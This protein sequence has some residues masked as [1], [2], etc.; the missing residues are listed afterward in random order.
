MA[1]EHLTE[2]QLHAYTRRSLPPDGLLSVSDHL[3]KCG[4]CRARAVR[5]RNESSPDLTY[6]ELVA[7]LDENTDPVQRRLLSEKLRHSPRSRAELN[8][9]LHFRQKLR[10][11]PPNE[12]GDNRV[13]VFPRTFLRVAL[14]LAAAIV[15]AAGA[16]WW[17]M[18]EKGKTITLRDA[19]RSI[20]L[21]PNGRLIGLAG[22]PN[23]LEHSV[24][25]ALRTGQLQIP[26]AI[27]GL[28]GD[29]GVLAGE[30][31]KLSEFRLMAPIATAVQE[32]R[33]RFCW[34]AQAGAE[35]YQIHIVDFESGETIVTGKSDGSKTEW[36]PAAPLAIGRIYQWQVDAV[37]NDEVIAR[38]PIPPEPEARF[39][40][41]GENERRNVESITQSAGGSHLANAVAYSEAGLLDD[42]AAQLAKLK[43]ENPGAT[44]PEQLLAQIEVTRCEKNSR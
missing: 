5:A 1:S 23:E 18:Q 40:V 31:N 32:A 3:A 7:Y 26:A 19:G 20:S 42:A 37:K 43:E 30:P 12:Y 28:V 39:K 22:L 25:T 10:A 41:L 29:R 27:R 36:T 16:I 33:P 21:Q 11:L 6:E 4:D 44:I 17:S 9:L 38:A 8:D 14:P 24:A 2:D 35:R 13:I 15:V 34:H